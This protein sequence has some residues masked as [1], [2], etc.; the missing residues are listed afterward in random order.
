MY[1]RSFSSITAAGLF[2]SFITSF[3]FA[4][5]THGNNSH[6]N[7]GHPR[8]G[9]G[10]LKVA[11][12]GAGAGGSSA[13]FFLGKAKE[14][15]GRNIKID[16]FERN[17]YIG[18]RSTIVHPYNDPSIEPRELGA[19]IFVQG[20]KNL[21][22][23]ASEFGLTLYSGEGAG[24]G[25]WDGSNFIVKLVGEPTDTDLV[26]KYGLDSLV[27]V[28][29]AVAS[30]SAQVDRCYRPDLFSWK[31]VENL[32][33]AMGVNYAVSKTGAKWFDSLGVNP[34]YSRE[35]IEGVTRVNYGQNI[36]QIHGIGAATSLAGTSALYSVTGGNRKIF[37]EYV[38]R[39]GAKVHL[40]TSVVA[41]VKTKINGKT[42]W[43]LTTKSNGSPKDIDCGLYDY[44]IL[45]APKGLSG[46]QFINSNANFPPVHY[47]KIH[48]TFVSTTSPFPKRSFFKQGS[49]GDIGFGTVLT[50]TDG[51]RKGGSL[52]DFNSIGQ[53]GTV[54][55][56]GRTEY[57]YKTFSLERRSDAWLEK[58]YGKG[59]LGWIYRKEWD[60][61][62]YLVPTTTYPPVKPDDGL[63]YVN[64]LEPW[65]STME[66]E[67]ISGRNAVDLLL[68]EAYNV[69]LCYGN[70]NV[71]EWSES[72]TETKVYGWDC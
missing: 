31:K 45:A 66:T 22:R 14:R 39:S 1:L 51:F 10:P 6:G 7:K 71:P 40:D 47:V 36:D 8:D 43:R 41:L 12:I 3:G 37:Q 25:L 5:P 17:S 52:P 18:G 56:N 63:F 70:N 61:Y 26:A 33:N 24:M 38:A 34:A 68:K 54:Q 30:F 62:P 60:A 35:F 50:T 20:N 27:K 29:N 23:A 11:V 28:D 72:E 21:V 42:K 65:T 32:S 49:S 64:S 2:L 4:A 57:I 16:V 69:G 15:F 55:R 9:D 13:A 44:V 48:V 19:S 46:I 53:Y 67:T 58:L 59:T